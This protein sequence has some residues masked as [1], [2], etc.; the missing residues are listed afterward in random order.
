MDRCD[1]IDWHPQQLEAM[2]ALRDTS[3]LLEKRFKSVNIIYL[4]F[5]L[6]SMDGVRFRMIVY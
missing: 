6:P 5:V 4:A 1:A 3:L 2:N